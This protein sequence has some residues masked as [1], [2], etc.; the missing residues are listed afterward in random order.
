MKYELFKETYSKFTLGQFETFVKIL[1]KDLVMCK[2][3]N[4]LL[5]I[6]NFINQSN[7]KHQWQLNQP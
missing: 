4:I 1:G 5:I 7:Q 6:N 2:L 3:I